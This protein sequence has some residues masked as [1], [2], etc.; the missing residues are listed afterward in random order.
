MNGNKIWKQ[1]NVFHKRKT[2]QHTPDVYKALQGQIKYY[3]DTRDI[4]NLPIAGVA[5][6]IKNIYVDAGPLYAHLTYLNVLRDAGLKKAFILGYDLKTRMPVNFNQHFVDAMLSF[7]H[8]DFLNTANDITQTTKDQIQNSIENGLNDGEDL[9]Y[10]I[11]GIMTSDIT[12]NR[13]ALIARTEVAK[14]SN[15]GE[16]VGTDKTGLQTQKEWLSV[17]D[18]RTRLD[19][20]ACDGQIVADGQPFDVGLEHFKMDRPGASVGADGR[21]IPAKEICN[22]RCTIGRHVERDGRGVPVMKPGREDLF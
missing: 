8:L 17:R 3:A 2:A 19:H 22:C 18:N 10:I 16:Q 20:L 7:F 6:A 11:N 21:A 4:N 14:A 5:E 15:Y 9:D 12:K 1:Y 13:A